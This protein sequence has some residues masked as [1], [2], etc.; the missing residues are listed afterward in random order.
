MA[1]DELGARRGRGMSS[2]S[3]RVRH[4]RKPARRSWFKLPPLVQTFQGSSGYLGVYLFGSEEGSLS[5]RHSLGVGHSVF[6]YSFG[7]DSCKGFFFF[8]NLGVHTLSD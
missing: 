7:S 4:G 1:P 8:F 2:H 3:S 5:S 6:S